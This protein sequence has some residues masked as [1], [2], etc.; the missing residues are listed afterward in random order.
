MYTRCRL[1]ISFSTLAHS[2]F[3][4]GV[5]GANEVEYFAS[6]VGWIIVTAHLCHQLDGDSGITIASLLCRHDELQVHGA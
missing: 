3:V 2:L 5:A 4:L 1:S 6:L